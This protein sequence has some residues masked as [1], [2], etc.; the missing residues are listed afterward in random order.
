VLSTATVADTG[1]AV[2][3]V[4]LGL[5]VVV[6]LGLVVVVGKVVDVLVVVLGGTVVL[7]EISPESPFPDQQDPK[8]ART[9]AVAIWVEAKDMSFSFPP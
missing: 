2:V 8:S 6:I 5:V 7:V 1:G 4:T 3:V 9:R